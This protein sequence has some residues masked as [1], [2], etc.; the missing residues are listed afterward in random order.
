MPARKETKIARGL[1]RMS[2]P[3]WRNI[4]AF[5]YEHKANG[6]L[7]WQEPGGHWVCRS[8]QNDKF[9]EWEE[10]GADPYDALRN[11]LKS[12]RRVRE[13][14]EDILKGVDE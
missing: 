4:S 12:V 10:I 8:D 11:W 6:L 14:A 3:G 1:A 7:I 5:D 2:W 13:W 9:C